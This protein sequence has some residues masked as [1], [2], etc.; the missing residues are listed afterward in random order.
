MQVKSFAIINMSLK[1][2]DGSK[3]IISLLVIA[4][5]PSLLIVWLRGR[6]REMEMTAVEPFYKGHHRGKKL[7]LASIERCPYL[8]GRFVL[9][10][11][12]WDIKMWPF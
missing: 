9:K 2:F 4:V 12:L 10:R 11:L 5:P 7:I 3:I 1:T 8:R 6:A